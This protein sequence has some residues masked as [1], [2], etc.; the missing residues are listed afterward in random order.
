M[1]STVVIIFPI[2]LIDTC[3]VVIDCFLFCVRPGLDREEKLMALGSRNFFLCRSANSMDAGGSGTTSSA[4]C[5][6]QAEKVSR[7][8]FSWLKFMDF[9]L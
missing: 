6:K 5:S 3:L 9:L 1:K 8:G 2:C 7:T 4:S